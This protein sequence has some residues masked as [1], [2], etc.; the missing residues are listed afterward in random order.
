MDQVKVGILGTSW[1]ADAMYLPALKNHPKARVEAVAGRNPETTRAFASRWEIQQDYE[2]AEELI[3]NADID[4]LIV[5]TS[6]D[7]HCPLTLKALERGL[8]VLCEKPLGLNFPEAAK[9]ASK[10]KESGVISMVPFTYSF[11]P[12]ARYLKDLIMEEYLAQPYH[13]N[14]RYYGG[15]GRKPGYLWRFDTRRGGTGALGDIGSHFLYIARWLFGEIV[16]VR[17]QL[18]RLVERPLLDPDGVEYPKADDTALISLSF[19]NGAQGIVHASTLAYEP[20]PFSQIHQ[21]E[22]HGSDGTLHSFTDWDRTQQV[23]GTRVGEG[24]LAVL[25]I[26]D[27]IWGKVRRDKVHDTYRDVF[28]IEGLMTGQFIDAIA[29]GKQAFPDFQEGA[30]IQRI[31]DAAL[32]SDLEHRSVSPM[33]IL[34]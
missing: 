19:E 18:D 15:G 23:S 6:N 27:R 2:N 4:A 13:L 20:T 21:M 16:Q 11:M 8:H 5:A 14:M 28:R 31:L 30:M 12:T 33:E 29:E 26:P 9:M 25:D 1:W 10:A 7:S 24:P 3:E 17:A 32:L 34:S 22:F